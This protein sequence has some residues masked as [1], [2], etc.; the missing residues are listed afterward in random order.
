MV[1]GTEVAKWSRDQCRRPRL[2]TIWGEES[3]AI[4]NL[5]K[6]SFYG[7]MPCQEDFFKIFATWWHRCDDVVASML[8][9]R[10]FVEGTS[11]K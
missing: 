3:K 1:S 4:A 9:N 6:T 7:V 2:R 5:A 8:V 10:A 11:R